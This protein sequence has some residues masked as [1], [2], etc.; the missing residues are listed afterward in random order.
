MSTLTKTP[1]GVRLRTTNAHCLWSIWT[2][3]NEQSHHSNP[4]VDLHF[5]RVIGLDGALKPV[6]VF[7]AFDTVSCDRVGLYQKSVKQR[8]SS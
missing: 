7:V 5:R 8:V 1:H 2:N 6:L 3:E 4:H